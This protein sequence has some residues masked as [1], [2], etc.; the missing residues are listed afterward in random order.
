MVDLIPVDHDPFA[1][2]LVPVD[3]DPFGI[4]PYVPPSAQ[5]EAMGKIASGLSK[6]IGGTVGGAVTLPGDVAAGRVSPLSNEAI[7]R[8]ADL[9]GLVTLGA[10]AAPAERDALGMGIRAYHG[11]PYDFERFDL[12]KIG[13]GE[14][15]QAYGHGLYFAENPAVAASYRPIKEPAYT[16]VYVR[17]LAKDALDKATTAGLEGDAAKRAAIDSLTQ[18]AKETTSVVARQHLY[19]AVNNFDV[20]IG[21]PPGKTYEVNINADPEHFLDRDK[22]LSEQPEKVRRALFEAGGTLEKGLPY[23]EMRENYLKPIEAALNGTT[24]GRFLKADDIL[25]GNANVDAIK[26]SLSDQPERVNAILA[27]KKAY[28]ERP[29][30]YENQDWSVTGARAYSKMT[31]SKIANPDLG[32][33]VEADE[34][35]EKIATAAL[36][37]AGI[38][39]IKYLDQGSREMNVQIFIAERDRPWSMASEANSKRASSI[40]RG[41]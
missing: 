34:P 40:P 29:T 17:A 9:A 27:A 25:S 22:P 35:Q 21:P 19:D 26:E 18:Q 23:G 20:A 41:G 33:G 39:G 10:G 15:A 2:N 28:D 32:F 11:S 14:G 38:P 31:E 12:S 3:Y 37:E 1:A 8:S 6:Q 4:A 36:R 30:K 13:T 5:S 7:G 24:P 16:G